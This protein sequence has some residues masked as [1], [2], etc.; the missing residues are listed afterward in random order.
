M[1]RNRQRKTDRGISAANLN[2]AA[3]DVR[4]RGISVRMAA[5]D[6][7]IPKTSLQRYMKASTPE[8]LKM[9]SYSGV[10]VAHS[11]FTDHQAQEL[12]DYIKT[13][14]NLFH[15]LSAKQCRELA[16]QYAAA[17]KLATIPNSWEQNKIAGLSSK[18]KLECI[19]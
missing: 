8:K 13:V 15:G 6:Y 16:Y 17:N 3:T 2:K 5:R 4:D 19:I 10:G 18:I 7:N 9:G 1:V 14:D 11:V 12:A